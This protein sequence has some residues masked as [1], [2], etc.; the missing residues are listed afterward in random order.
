M[1][2]TF[3]GTTWNWN[4]GRTIATF[5]MFGLLLAFFVVQQRLAIFTTRENRMFPPGRLFRSRSQ[6]LLNIEMFLASWA[7]FVPLYYIP[8]YFQFV[9]GDTAIMAAV[10]LLPFVTILIVTN[11]VAGVLLPRI[12]YY[13]A[14]YFAAGILVT[15]GSCLM[16][17]ITIDS[18]PAHIYG[19]SVL[20]ALGVGLIFNAGYSI[21]GIKMGAKGGSTDDINAVVAVQNMSQIGG[22]LTALLVAG[23]VFQSIAFRKLTVL[24]RDQG[25]TDAQVRSVAA[26]STSLVFESLSPSLARKAVEAV[27]ST[28]S[29]IYV[30][31][32]VSGGLSL[33]CS[34]LLKR[35]R[36]FKP[37]TV[38]PSSA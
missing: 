35:E 3:A 10:R 22:V 4:D 34:L 25:F 38:S 26:G 33:L 8:N 20:I 23:Q 14:L 29:T 1:V 15:V 17:T 36:L 5:V 37:T 7:V 28:I 11:I 18:P 30:L 16:F 13:A 32:I 19:F 6:I 9:H 2:L 27:T 21:A 24:L 12:S 31:T